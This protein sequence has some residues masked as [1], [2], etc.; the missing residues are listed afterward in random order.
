MRLGFAWLRRL[1]KSQGDR[2]IDLIE[3][4][5]RLSRNAASSKMMEIA[6]TFS[7][8]PNKVDF[9]NQSMYNNGCIIQ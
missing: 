8:S 5:I 4:I 2:C 9:Y 7:A 3:Y 1:H 6:T